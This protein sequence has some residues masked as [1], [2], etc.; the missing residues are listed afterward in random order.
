M[1]VDDPESRVL[2][3]RRESTVTEEQTFTGVRRREREREV[4]R[5]IQRGTS[6]SLESEFKE[7]EASK[8][9]SARDDVAQ[10]G[11]VAGAILR[12]QEG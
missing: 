11:N 9:R 4:Y 7:D 8:N 12:S 6:T 10:G 5:N 3:S 1:T 2:R